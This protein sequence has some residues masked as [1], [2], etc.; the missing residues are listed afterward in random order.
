[1]VDQ[2]PNNQPPQDGLASLAIKTLQDMVVAINGWTQAFINVWPRTTGTFTLAVAATTTV[3]QPA[4]RATSVVQLSPTN[5]LAATLMGSSKAL[6]VSAITPGTGFTV[7]T[8]D[9]TNATA[10]TFSYAI[11]S[12]S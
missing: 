6:Y 11:F 3:P 4:I 9:G 5:A 1:M 2:R 10:G 7:A 12:P 8:A